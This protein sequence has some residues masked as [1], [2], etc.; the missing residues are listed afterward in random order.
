MTKLKNINT[1]GFKIS[2]KKHVV[3]IILI[4]MVFSCDSKNTCYDN[5]IDHYD[6]I[7][8]NNNELNIHECYFDFL[9]EI[10]IKDKKEIVSIPGSSVREMADT[11]NNRLE[12][13]WEIRTGNFQKFYDSQII[14]KEYLTYSSFYVE[15]LRKYSKTESGNWLKD[16]VKQYTKFNSISPSMIPEFEALI[17]KQNLKRKENRIVILVHYLTLSNN[18]QDFE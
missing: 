1:I 10:R 8:C 4:T 15:Y 3:F 7:L 5:F 14:K 6:R 16:Y 18:F 12:C 2:T 13:F 17:L 11:F 9:S